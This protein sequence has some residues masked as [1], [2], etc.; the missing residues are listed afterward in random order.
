MPHILYVPTLCHN[1]I[2]VGSLADQGQTIVFIK[3]QYL[4]L[5][6]ISNKHILAIGIRNLDNGLYHFQQQRSNFMRSIVVNSLST[7][8]NSIGLWHDRFGHV[9]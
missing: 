3:S 6:N 9:H 4:I 5:D 8:R 1:L 7:F 2:S